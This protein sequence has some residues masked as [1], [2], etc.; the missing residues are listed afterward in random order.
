[1]EK[2]FVKIKKCKKIDTFDSG[3]KRNGWLLEILSDKDK[4][5][6]NLRG[7]VYLSVV[8]PRMK[9][10]F[11]IH[12][13]AT[14]FLT[15]IKGKIKSVVYTGRRRKREIRMGDGN[16]KT[17]R[18]LPGTAHLICNLGNEESYILVYRHPSWDANIK[19]QLDISEQEIRT[20]ESWVK[21]NKFVR[22]N[23]NS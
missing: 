3:A 22:I 16:Y 14:Y 2:N 5:S 21:I 17:I 11:H 23:K 1:M 9:K 10:G 7:Q 13:R 15:C 6:E 19:E 4:F 20:E 8:A 12:G 18:L